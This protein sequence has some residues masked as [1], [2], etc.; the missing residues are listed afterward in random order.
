VPRI[1]AATVV[2]HRAA[3][4]RALLDA[5]RAILAETGESPS[6]AGIGARAG[7]AR[8]SVYQY[9]R[10]REDL[11]DAVV[12]DTFPRWLRRI[13]AAMDAAGT[14]GAQVLAYVE[15]NLQLV[16]DGEHAVARALAAIAPSDALAE[17]SRVMHEQLRTPVV[18]ALRAHGAADPDATADLV[19]ALVWTGSRMIES[20]K[21]A[22][23]VRTRV[24]ELLGPYLTQSG[25]TTANESGGEG[26]E[27]RPA[28]R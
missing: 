25:R 23:V 6:L 17:K 11:L 18:D 4:R 7:L 10:S 13:T 15:E 3:Q 9:F 14:P 20:G 16:A 21:E 28:G 5:A 27:T 1:K 24:A 12:E 26:G 2:E 8:P 22:A 19:N